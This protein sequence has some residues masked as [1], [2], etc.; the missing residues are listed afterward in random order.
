MDWEP[1]WNALLESGIDRFLMGTAQRTA[2][3]LWRRYQPRLAAD[4]ALAKVAPLWRK[5]VAV[6]VLA[7]GVGGVLAYG[8]AG[9]TPDTA[10]LWTMAWFGSVSA[11]VWLYGGWLV[12]RWAVRQTRRL[13]A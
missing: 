8:L 1:F 7:W 12:A 5:A 4:Y 9:A 3:W 2:Q 10:P 6:P 11:A 13:V